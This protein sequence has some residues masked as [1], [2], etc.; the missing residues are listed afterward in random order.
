MG[1]A[2]A[3]DRS[4]GRPWLSGRRRRRANVEPLSLGLAACDAMF[5]DFAELSGKTL[6]I[7]FMH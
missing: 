2:P 4:S 7:D 1:V 3:R 6:H 5:A